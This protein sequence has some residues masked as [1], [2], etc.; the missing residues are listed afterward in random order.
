MH[1]AIAYRL[2]LGRRVW[3]Q[4]RCFDPSLTDKVMRFLDDISW[5][6]QLVIW[7]LATT[8]AQRPLSWLMPS[9]NLAPPPISVACRDS[10]NFY[11]DNSCKLQI[12]PQQVLNGGDANTDWSVY[13]LVVLDGNPF[14]LGQIDAA[15]RFQ[16]LVRTKATNSVF[17]RGSLE[18]RDTFPVKI[19]SLDW[20][21][22]ELYA[23]DIFQVFEKSSSWEDTKSPYYTGQVKFSDN[24]PAS[25]RTSISDSLEMAPCDSSFYAKIHRKFQAIDAAGQVADTLQVIVFAKPDLSILKTWPNQEQ[26]TCTPLS[27]PPKTYFPFWLNLIGDSILL[28]Q[29][30]YGL[31]LDLQNTERLL[32]Q[33]G[34]SSTQV[35]RILE[36]CSGQILKTDTVLVRIGDLQ[37]PITSIT[38][39]A[40]TLAVQPLSCT[41]TLSLNPGVLSREWGLGISD[42]SN[43]TIKG[44]VKTYLPSTGDSS[45]QTQ[46]Y[47]Q[48]NGLI[49]NLPLGKHRLLLE[50]KDECQNTRL[51]SIYFVVKD[52]TAPIARC[53]QSLKLVLQKGRVKLAA[54]AIDA[55]SNDNC[56][57]KKYLA[58]RS[59]DNTCLTDFDQNKNG[60]LDLGDGL[61]QLGNQFYTKASDTLNFSCCDAEKQIEIVLVLED[62]AGNRSTCNARVLIQD[63]DIPLL[64]APQDTAMLCTE[65]NPNKLSLYGIAKTVNDLCER[66]KVIELNPTSQTNNCGVGTFT[67]RWQAVKN[68]GQ[69]NELR[70]PIVEQKIE[71]QTIRDYAV[72]FPPDTTVNCVPSPSKV[73]PNLQNGCNVLSFNVIDKKVESTGNECYQVLRTYQVSSWCELKDGAKPIILDRDV[74]GNGYRGDQ[75]FWLLLRPD[76][77]T[78]IDR[79]SDEKNNIPD[80][81]GHWIN[82]DERASLTSTG[83]WEYTQVIKVIDREAPKITVF[84]GSE[85]QGRYDNCS[86]DV[87]ISFAVAENCGA[88][89]LVVGVEF[90]QNSDGIIDQNVTSSALSGTFPRYRIVGR[91]P[92]GRHIFK[93]TARDAC[94][95]ET[96]YDFPISIIDKKGPQPLCVNGIVVDLQPLPQ[97]E[98]MDGD[99]DLDIASAGLFAKDMIAG[100]AKD[101]SKIVAYSIHR[102][103]RIESGKEKP[104]PSKTGV[105]F[106][107]DD[108][109]SV[110]VYI[111]AW[112]ENGNAGFCETY[113]LV[114]DTRFNLCPKPGTTSIAGT[115]LS[116][117]GN[118][119]VGAEI[120][121]T[122]SQNSQAAVGSDGKYSF[123]NLSNRQDYRLQPSFEG[124]YLSGVTTRDLVLINMHI[125]GELPFDSPY[126]FIAADVDSSGFV[127]T[128]DMIQIRKLVLF[129]DSR[130]KNVP[131]WRFIPASYR[132]ANPLDPL[133]EPY[134]NFLQLNSLEG[135]RTGVDFI[136]IKMG[137]ING[138]VKLNLGTPEIRNAPISL[139]TLDRDLYF[140]QVIDLKLDLPAQLQAKGWQLALRF[141]SAALELV[142]IEKIPGLDYMV[143]GE[144]IRFSY[145]HPRNGLDETLPTLR[146]KAKQAGALSKMLS[147]GTDMKAE[148][149]DQDLSVYPLQ[150]LWNKANVTGHAINPTN[151]PTLFQNIPNPFREQTQVR[152][153]LPQ[154]AHGIFCVKDLSGKLLFRLEKDFSAGSNFIEISQQ[155]LISSGL[156][157]YTLETPG[158][159][160]AQKM[161][162]LR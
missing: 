143:D 76:G 79:D 62:A 47:P 60:R 104:D 102:A 50:I 157:V 39:G 86:G 24:C 9:A 107:C 41:A 11:F 43:F 80:A 12:E 48:N 5:S 150:L 29:D 160:T 7:A 144:T 152:F 22:P 26:H 125:L 145:V 95:N 136:G 17:C 32:C 84:S 6:H 91:F 127:S 31:S 155:Q 119:V 21:Q 106:T 1:L 149:Y 4:I 70:G 118:P 27:I 142:Q 59:V 147:L 139:S 115:I 14:N 46:T 109:P 74:D 42:C 72:Y 45:W 137:D 141:Q 40:K 140:A 66:A 36:S 110:L 19:E 94:G 93:I 67:R 111:Y 2:G 35:F 30:R 20:Q 69:A 90:D 49:S 132:F 37:A 25:L 33:R 129:I 83:L 23:Y 113:V 98:D 58:Q 63:F 88:K 61:V 34:R 148:L 55:G 10:L 101:C 156:L 128:L 108:R 81:K 99:G 28:D 120:K 3:S 134:P 123:N 85:F 126:Q 78:Y 116:R 121:L 153:D 77:K 159:V 92:L 158:F 87:N 53:Q 73:L 44:Q 138:D 105:N 114:R 103:D 57:V 162:L 8:F 18:A 130:F 51:D 154:A 15:G 97:P 71:V 131:S 100:E 146:F 68:Q 117:Q 56:N 38:A 65:F 133:K 161:L 112:D 64:Q 135:E 124:P 89:D 52:L 75:G 151:S 13:E 96:S 54:S 122:G 16:Y 82:S